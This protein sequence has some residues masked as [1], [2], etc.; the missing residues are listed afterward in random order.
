MIGAFTFVAEVLGPGTILVLLIGLVVYLVYTLLLLAHSCEM[1]RL[2]TI[3]TL[4]SISWAIAC[5]SVMASTTELALLNM[6]S[7]AF[8]TLMF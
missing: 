1:V 3:P 5:S 8:I 7:C 2:T 4:L 6:S